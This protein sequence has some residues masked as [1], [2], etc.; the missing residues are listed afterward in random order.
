MQGKRSILLTFIKL[1]IVIN[2]CVFLCFVFLFLVTVLL[3]VSCSV[4]NLKV[5]QFQFS[6]SWS[7]I[8]PNGTGQ[9]DPDALNYYNNIINQLLGAQVQPVVVLYQSDLPQAFVDKGG[10]LNPDIAG[11][12]EK[13]ANFC[14]STFGSRVS[15]SANILKI[16][17]PV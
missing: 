12:F 9:A 10:W 6:V 2:I 3:Y 4:F 14:F 11:W 15:L 5:Q 8:F 16:N 7:S 17:E 1:P 13:Y